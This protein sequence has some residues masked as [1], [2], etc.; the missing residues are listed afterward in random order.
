M[1]NFG[2][3]LPGRWNERPELDPQKFAVTQAGGGKYV[4]RR[5]LPLRRP[6][7]SRRPKP[8]AQAAPT[9][10]YARDAP[11]ARTYL[12]DL[13][14]QEG[15]QVQVGKDVAAW[16]GNAI[17]PLTAQA[18]QV[19]QAFSN[20]AQAGATPTPL[21]PAGFSDPLGYQTQADAKMG[22]ETGL[23]GRQGASAQS[24]MDA[25]AIGALG[26][27]LLASA[28]QQVRDIPALFAKQRTEY[29]DKVNQFVAQRN[30]EREQMAEDRRRWEAEQK[31]SARARSFDERI[32]LEGLGLDAAKL[33]MPNPPGGLAGPSSGPAPIGKQWVQRADGGW[34]LVDDGTG[35]GGGGGG[36]RPPG[37]YTRNELAKQ[38][39]VGGWKVKPKLRVA[40]VQADDGSWW[41]KPKTGKKGGGGAAPKVKDAVSF[42]DRW[43]SGDIDKGITGWGELVTS[44]TRTK[45][46][47]AN[48]FFR[49]IER[50]GLTPE[51]DI[52]IARSYF[53]DEEI[54]QALG[55]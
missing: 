10:P 20:A 25:G 21:M 22:A 9:D 43:W 26:Q 55:A 3:I 14:R 27:S 35:A 51:Q 41:A 36:K 45:Q 12:D 49:L 15:H 29:E 23:Y 52:A 34:E 46:N 37:T 13:S 7:P 19:N 18:T 17:T 8:L 44:G 42:F 31:A 33:A 39:F 54:R 4:A 2:P 24:A 40:P 16:L 48:R 1:A 6:L 11:W 38:G 47:A 5:R 50:Y 28:G 30:F 32:T 53:T